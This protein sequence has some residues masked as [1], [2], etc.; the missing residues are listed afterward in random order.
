MLND[1]KEIIA[2][3]SAN[4]PRSAADAPFG[5]E[6]RNALDWFLNKSSEYGLKVGEKKGFY[7]W[8]EYG[9]QDAPII[10]V[11]I[12]LDIVPVGDGWTGDPLAL[13]IED[14]KA[15]GRGVSDDKGP[16]VAVMWALKRIK[17]EGVKLR[18]RVRIIAGCNEETGRESMAEYISSDE[19]PVM[20]FVPDAEFPV[21][22]SE[23]GILHLNARLAL[24]ETFTNSVS[25]L[26]GGKTINVVPASASVTLKK[27]GEAYQ[28]L[29]EQSDGAITDAIFKLPRIALRLVEIGA[30]AS[31]FT[32][33]ED[34]TG[35]TFTAN[36]VAG[37]ASTPELGDNAIWKIFAL[38]RAL[39]PESQTVSA[40]YDNFCRQDALNKIDAFYSDEESGT[41]T[42]SLDLLERSDGE[43]SFSFD[44]RIPLCAT[45][46]L[47]KEKIETALKNKAPSL[48]VT[49][50]VLRFNENLFV[51]KDSPLVKTL[52]SVY[53]K[54]TGEK[55]TKPLQIGGGT[56]ARDFPSAV[57]FGPT[58]P[59][60][61]TNIHN[62]DENMP[63]E[64]L[65]KLVEIYYQTIL[66]LDKI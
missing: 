57:A 20:S 37:H 65:Y 11:P 10:G 50:T 30:N 56:Y 32:I 54:I 46:E 34:E 13:R 49:A 48:A 26:T 43:L 5:Q 52:L 51:P 58:F 7:G 59:G 38:L 3:N 14:G 2:I 42:M 33:E 27:D 63:V 19:I 36:G 24:D 1:L 45:P 29:S 12:H 6:V 17:E 8:A 61:E 41:I 15:Y 16:T 44:F 21:I 62:A 31:E 64:D 23:R 18:H 4:A 22:N 25:V 66:E 60:V 28:Y 55:N 35:L 40:V 47:I 39:L 9:P 53:E